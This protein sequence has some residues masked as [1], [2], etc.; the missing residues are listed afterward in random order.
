VSC[1]DTD[2]KGVAY[3]AYQATLPWA[4]GTEYYY[5]YTTS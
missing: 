5:P 1:L 2:V 3:T 4:R